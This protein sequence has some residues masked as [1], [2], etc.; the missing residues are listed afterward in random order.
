M[1]QERS[2]WEFSTHGDIQARHPMNWK[3]P[4]EEILIFYKK[5]INNRKNKN[6]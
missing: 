2:I 1:T 6:R 5:M 3:N 4:D